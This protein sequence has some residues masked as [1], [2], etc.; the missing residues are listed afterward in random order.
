[1]YC[2]V[3]SSYVRGGRTGRTIEEERGAGVDNQATFWEM[4]ETTCLDERW[5]ITLFAFRYINSILEML[6]VFEK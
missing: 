4:W 2:S 6:G 3:I 5:Y 1:M